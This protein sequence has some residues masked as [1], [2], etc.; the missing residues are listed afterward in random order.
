MSQRGTHQHR[1]RDLRSGTRL[2]SSSALA[3]THG[4][5]PADWRVSGPTCVA[6]DPESFR[7][8]TPRATRGTRH[9]PEGRTSSP[10]WIEGAL[11]FFCSK[12][13]APV[14][15]TLAALVESQ[16]GQSAIGCGMYLEAGATDEDGAQRQFEGGAGGG[17]NHDGP[18]GNAKSGA[19][20]ASRASRPN[21]SPIGA[22]ITR[23]R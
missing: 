11:G 2:G 6:P 22:T 3:F 21:T 10:V 13:F 20:E 1:Q 23:A 12:T 15:S 8:D 4:A 5:R 19:N 14:A 18:I 7:D 9:P 17:E 16:E